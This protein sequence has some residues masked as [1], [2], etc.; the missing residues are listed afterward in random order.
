MPPSPTKPSRKA[1]GGQPG[2]K[3]ALKHGFYSAL[4][5]PEEVERFSGSPELRDEQQLLRAT[6]FRIA[7]HLRFDTLNQAELNGA[8]HLL[9]AIQRIATI[10]RTIQLSHGRGGEL[11]KTILEALQEMNPEEDLG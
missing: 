11:G 7:R 10:E 4:F 2:N 1:S 6:A 9:L 3:N 8:F 5:T